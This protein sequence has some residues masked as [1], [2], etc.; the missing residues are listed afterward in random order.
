MSERLH[1]RL[2]RSS[3]GLAVAAALTA[4][5]VGVVV[6]YA[7][8]ATGG[9]T[10]SFQSGTV[11]AIAISSPSVG[12]LYPQ[13][14]SAATTPVTV[15]V[16]NTGGTSQV[17]GQITGAVNTS[18]GCL[19]SWFTVA[20]IPAPGSLAPGNHTFSSSVI[21]NDTGIDQDACIN[22]SVTI[23]WTSASG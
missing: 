9:G 6:A 23:S 8:T 7:A 14:S 10:A 13:L 16:D 18:G 15:T 3:R 22:K 19:G 5:C 11:G 20:S 21:L 1:I 4:A 2:P 12:P 17:V